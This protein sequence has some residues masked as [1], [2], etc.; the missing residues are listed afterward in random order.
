MSLLDK[1]VSNSK[2][3]IFKFTFSLDTSKANDK[4]TKFR[5]FFK[6]YFSFQKILKL[7]ST[8]YHDL[9]LIVSIFRFDQHLHN[10]YKNEFK[11]KFRYYLY[12]NNFWFLLTLNDFSTEDHDDIA[13]NNIQANLSISLRDLAHCFG[14]LIQIP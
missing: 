10:F 14:Y 6:E 9:M 2:Q 5:T 3:S 4:P 12:L 11:S 7:Q 1:N 8:L 13:S